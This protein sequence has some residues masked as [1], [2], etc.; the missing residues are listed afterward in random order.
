[1]I[2]DS[3][4]NIGNLFLIS[5]LATTSVSHLNHFSCLLLLLPLTFLWSIYVSL[6]TGQYWYNNY[7]MNTPFVA[8]KISILVPLIRQCCG[9]LT[10]RHTRY[11]VLRTARGYPIYWKY[12]LVLV[13]K[14]F[15]L[16]K[17]CQE[18]DVITTEQVCLLFFSSFFHFF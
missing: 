12:F 17:S 6:T 8:S 10:S 16:T 18:S 13:E 1:L 15:K 14:C 3:Q 5:V 7:V 9:S 4:M 11:S 2:T